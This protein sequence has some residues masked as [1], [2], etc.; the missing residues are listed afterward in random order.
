MVI[1]MCIDGLCATISLTHSHKTS[2][3]SRW[4]VFLSSLISTSSMAFV[5]CATELRH[6]Q[7]MNTQTDDQTS[8][9]INVAWWG[10]I[11]SCSAPSLAV[12]CYFVARSI[13]CPHGVILSVYHA[14]AFDAAKKEMD[15][16]SS[17]KA[18]GHTP[19]FDR[20]P[21]TAFSA[22]ISFFPIILVAC[23]GLTKLLW[24]VNCGKLSDWGQSAA[25]VTTFAGGMYW[26]YAFVCDIIHTSQRRNESLTRRP[27][28]TPT[29]V[30]H[31]L[32][33]SAKKSIPRL[34]TAQRKELPTRLRC[35]RNPGVAA[36]HLDIHQYRK[37]HW[38]Q[39]SYTSHCFADK[40][41]VST[42]RLTLSS[43]RTRRRS[44]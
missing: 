20:I 37:S 16:K 34:R 23:V 6:W 33:E 15:A 31:K 32:F 39:G 14:F 17:N 1:C 19:W 44:S 27:T 10:T 29:V 21:G 13:T 18:D 38:L 5:I 43:T 12:R 22:W 42:S 35:E 28:V 40:S 26:L 7:K 8:C 25:V 30:V 36:R 4:Y 9:C 41:K 2:L 24:A 11:T 3:A